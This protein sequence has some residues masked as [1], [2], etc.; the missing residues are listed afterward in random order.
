MNMV[1]KTSE[2][3]AN[4]VM[5]LFTTNLKYQDPTEPQDTTKFAEL[6]LNISQIQNSDATKKLLDKLNT[7]LSKTNNVTEYASLINREVVMDNSTVNVVDKKATINYN[8]GKEANNTIISLLDSNGKIVTTLKAPSKKGVNTV[9][10]QEY[11]IKDIP[12]GQYN[13]QISAFSKT[14]QNVTANTKVRQVVE[15]IVKQNDKIFV[16]SGNNILPL[17]QVTEIYKSNK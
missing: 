10:L 2:F 16:A 17:D 6:I 5:K 8:L 7:T 13:V 14:G 15:G 12:D 4:S 1:N 11:N 3:S 9:K